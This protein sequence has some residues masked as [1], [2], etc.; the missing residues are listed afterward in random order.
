MRI[1]RPS[2][3]ASRIGLCDRQLREM[4][5]D[6]LFPKRFQINPG[7]GRAAGHLESEV[8]QWIKERAETRN[9]AAA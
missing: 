9:V 3:T 2:D 7:N 4:E 1:L 6:G 5:A 8:E